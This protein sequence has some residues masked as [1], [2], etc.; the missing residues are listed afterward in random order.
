MDDRRRKDKSWDLLRYLG[1][2]YDG[3]WVVIGDF[4][5]ILSNEEKQGGQLW[6]GR[7]M[8]GFRELEVNRLID[9]GFKRRWYM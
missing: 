3:L 5:E 8:S 6:E 2:R 1:W 7:M 4:N 9:I